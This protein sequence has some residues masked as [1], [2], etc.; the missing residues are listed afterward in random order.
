MFAEPTIAA[1][2]HAEPVSTKISVGNQAFNSYNNED[3]LTTFVCFGKNGE[4]S[5]KLTL[6]PFSKIVYPL[7]SVI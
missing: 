3:Y 6:L 5:M 4:F 2:W 7:G 1:P